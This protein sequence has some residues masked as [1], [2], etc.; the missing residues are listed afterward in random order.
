MKDWLIYLLNF[1]PPCLGVNYAVNKLL[2][3]TLI[4]YRYYLYLTIS[5]IKD[6]I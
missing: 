1:S 3:T 2:D 6:L 4:L 5:R